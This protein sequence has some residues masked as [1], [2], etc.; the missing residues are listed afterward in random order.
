MEAFV[1]RTPFGKC[2]VVADNI[3]FQAWL[4]KR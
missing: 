1:A 4:E 2:R 3:S